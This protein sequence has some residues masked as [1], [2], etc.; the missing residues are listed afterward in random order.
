MKILNLSFFYLAINL[1]ISCA[2]KN[3]KTA[4]VKERI[5]V[6]HKNIDSIELTE[7][8]K[9]VYE[10]HN[11]KRLDDFPY[12]YDE[13]KDSIFIGIDW[14]KY[15]NNIQLFKQTNFF[16]TDF[17]KN[18]KSIAQT[19]DSS[20]RKADITW[21]NINDGIPLWE[22][23]ADNWCGCQ[24]YPEEYWKRLTIDSLT[25]NQGYANFIW[26]WDKDF[27]HSYK[28]TAKKEDGKWKINSLDGFKYFYTVEEYDKMM[29]EKE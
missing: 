14:D 13:K 19:L 1:L 21:R 24:D 23:N 6:D 10:W 26:T 8:V 5:T 20:I 22:T 2:E 28:V 7:L 11:S 18:H 4:L 9:E 3:E 17:I 27:P 29:K 12:K 16:S 15:K 25:L